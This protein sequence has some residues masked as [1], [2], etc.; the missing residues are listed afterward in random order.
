MN[1]EL[2]YQYDTNFVLAF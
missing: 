2:L 1:D